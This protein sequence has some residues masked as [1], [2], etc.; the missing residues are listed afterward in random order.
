M[1]ISESLALQETIVRSVADGLR[2]F[3]R[4]RRA[5]LVLDN[6]EHVLDAAP[7]VTAM[8]ATCP[9]L[10]ALVSSRAILRLS[11]EH[12]L[13]VP[14]LALPALDRMPPLPELAAVEAVTLFLRRAEA[15]N[16]S[17]ALTTENAVAVAELCVELDGLPLAIELAAAR[18]RLFS[19]QE[20]LT[21]ATNRL[22][23]LTGGPRDQPL[24]LRTIRDA[25]AWSHDLLTVDEQA[26]FRRLSIFVGGFTA[27]ATV[28]VAS[29]PDEPG[30]NM[31]AEARVAAR[32]QP[33]TTR[34]SA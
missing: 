20:L 7:L 4:N 34:E 1:A 13:T 32:P 12:V 23:L 19:P 3:L 30:F 6:F 2:V 24:R 14:P 27:E 16:A 17:F 21:L 10:K 15:A 25:I 22:A 31:L 28:A 18:T 9:R 11:G 26:I 8:L 33:G 5:L 29:A